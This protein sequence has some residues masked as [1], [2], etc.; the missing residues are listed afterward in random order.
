MQPSAEER[1]A[2]GVEWAAAK[3]GVAQ[4]PGIGVFGMRD[5]RSDPL[6]G[7]VLADAA[8][9]NAVA[10][11]PPAVAEAAQVLFRQPPA[12]W[13]QHIAEEGRGFGR[14]ADYGLVR[15]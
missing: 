10:Q 6:R 3:E 11:A 13:R 9:A 2:G 4:P 14:C 8:G 7:L 15:V 1:I 5:P 12:A